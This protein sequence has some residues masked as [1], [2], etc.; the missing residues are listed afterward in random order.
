M[1][2]RS[3]Q[4]F[5]L[6]EPLS[7]MPNPILE[8]YRGHSVPHLLQEHM[9]R[10][11]GVA[12]FILSHWKGPFVAREP[13]LR[14]LL[15]HDIGNIVKI[16]LRHP[17]MLSADDLNALPLLLR[18]QASYRERFGLDDHVASLELAREIGLS[19]HELLLMDSKI[20]TRNEETA[21]SSDFSRK[22]GAYA[23]QRC[24]PFGV[25]TLKTRLST[26]DGATRTAPRRR[27]MRLKGGR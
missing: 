5:S 19:R 20:F 9:L 13:L 16:D 7:A 18:V 4:T 2:A 3:G 14:V 23:D 17:L 24:A 6:S 8:V 11:A 25:T 15:V 27:S 21:R 10:V 26:I 22:I 1:K 12:D